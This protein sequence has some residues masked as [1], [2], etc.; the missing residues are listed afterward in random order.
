VTTSKIYEYIRTKNGGILVEVLNYIIKTANL[1]DNFDSSYNQLEKFINRLEFSHDIEKNENYKE[2]QFHFYNSNFKY[3][4]F[5]NNLTS[6]GILYNELRLVFNVNDFELQI[7]KIESGSLLGKILG[8]DN[9]IESLAYLL[10]KCIDLI[11]N[12]FTLE[13]KLLRKK[14]LMDFIEKSA[15]FPKKCEELGLK[16]NEDHKNLAKENISKAYAVISGE[17]LKMAAQSYKISIDN[18]VFSIQDKLTEK[19]LEEGKKLILT[20]NTTANNGS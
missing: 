6:I 9:I 19:Y 1:Y 17:I 20:E 7:I 3:K 15:E 4:D 8:N 11:F 2:F 13:G 14:E 18:E 16:L 12:K 10:K 5:L